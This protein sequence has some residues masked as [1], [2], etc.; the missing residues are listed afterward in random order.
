[1][2]DFVWNACI[3]LYMMTNTTYTFDAD[4]VSDLHKDAHGFR[5]RE[6]FW[7][8]WDAADIDG[9]QAIW[10]C[11]IED[12]D[13][14]VALE[15]R[16]QQESIAA[17]EILVSAIMGEYNVSRT[18]AIRWMRDADPMYADI[19]HFEWDNGL[20]FGYCKEK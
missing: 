19:E 6:A 20:P 12:L 3:I 17:F 15:K 1:V 2:V 10:D 14:Q 16:E 9:K 7:S 13:Y 5:P 8:R 11:L 4:I 18:D